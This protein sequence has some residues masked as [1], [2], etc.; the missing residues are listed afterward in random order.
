MPHGSTAVAE[1]RRAIQRGEPCGVVGPCSRVSRAP[2]FTQDRSEAVFGEPC[3]VEPCRQRSPLHDPPDGHASGA[4]RL[5]VPWAV[6]R[7]STLAGTAG[8]AHAADD[9]TDGMRGLSIVVLGAGPAGLSAALALGR[10]GHRVTLI[11]R[12]PVIVDRPETASSWQR[13]GIPHFHQPHAFIP[14]GRLEL[15]GSFPDVYRSLIDHGASDVD[16][17]PKIRGPSQRQDDEPQYLAARRP[18]IEWALRRAVVS[19]PR[20][21]VRSGVQALGYEATCGAP[22]RVKGVATRAAR[23]RPTSWSTRWVGEVP[24]RPGSGRTGLEHSPGAEHA[25]LR[26]TPARVD[27]PFNP[28]EARWRAERSTRCDRWFSGRLD[29]GEGGE[30]GQVPRGS[31]AA[32]AQP[33]WWRDAARSTEAWGRSTAEGSR[34]KVGNTRKSGRRRARA[35]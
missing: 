34:R 8:A 17:R 28:P 18:L 35:D 2:H 32:A 6:D 26:P 15:L 24:R 7:P 10:D 20:I 19:E 13:A 12:D 16:P 3:R 14:R 27:C 4:L 23:L 22:L 11:E 33:T 31:P 25:Y 29:A 30:S 5:Q 1:P 9:H 21:Q